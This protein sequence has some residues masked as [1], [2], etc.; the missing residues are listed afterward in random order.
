MLA[1]DTFLFHSHYNQPSTT[2]VTC[3]LYCPYAQEDSDNDHKGN[4]NSRALTLSTTNSSSQ[5][6]TLTLASQ[7]PTP[8]G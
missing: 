6:P 4:N 8:F 2:L 3:W 1:T 5:P 7:P